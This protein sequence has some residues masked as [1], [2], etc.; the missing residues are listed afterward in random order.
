MSVSGAIL[1][2]VHGLCELIQ[3][4]NGQTFTL[5]ELHAVVGGMIEIQALPKTGSL[6][7]LNEEGKGLDLP[8]NDRATALW[9]QNYPADEDPFAQAD[10]IS[11]R[12]LICPVSM[13]D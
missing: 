10:W 6:M 1:I 3:P 5:A 11:G 9:R 7:V 4:A 2:P 13:I 12:V 8:E